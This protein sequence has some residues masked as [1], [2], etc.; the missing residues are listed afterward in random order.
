MDKSASVHFFNSSDSRLMFFELDKAVV[1]SDHDFLNS[2]ELSKLSSNVI[3]T[4]LPLKSR[5]VNLGKS[6]R[7]SIPVVNAAGATFA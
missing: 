4:R 6:L 3:F 2:S 7:V 1:V 5:D